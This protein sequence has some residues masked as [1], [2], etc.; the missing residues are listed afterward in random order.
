MSGWTNEEA[1]DDDEGEGE[2]M[3][4]SGYQRRSRNFHLTRILLKFVANM[5]TSNEISIQQ[6]GLLKD[7][8]VDQN[9]E[10]CVFI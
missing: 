5:A 4:P 7:R 10:V 1:Y 3:E 2:A 9:E 6:K 8:I